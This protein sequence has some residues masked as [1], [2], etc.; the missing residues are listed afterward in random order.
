MVQHEAGHFLMGHLLGY[1][2][3]G[4]SV[5]AVKNAVEIYPLADADRGL[6]LFGN[7]ALERR[8]RPFCRAGPAKWSAYRAA[9]SFAAT[10]T[11][12]EYRLCT[13]CRIVDVRWDLRSRQQEGTLAAFKNPETF[14][15]A[16]E[17][18]VERLAP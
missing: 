3:K 12:L 8:K 1:P 14:W 17:Y 18:L 4:Y 15:Y 7:H 9:W 2:V 11:V 13:A 6:D 10:S 16:Q 5:N